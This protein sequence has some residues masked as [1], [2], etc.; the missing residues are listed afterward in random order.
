M[1]PSATGF[2]VVRRGYDQGQ[3]E[4][5]LRRLEAGFRLIATDRDAAVDQSAQLGRELDDARA[6][7]E[8]LRTQVRT[9]VSPPQSVQ[10]I[11]ERMRAM[12]RMA[13]DEVGEMLDNAKTTVDQRVREAEAQAARTVS[14]ARAEA[15]EVLVQA[16]TT[17]ERNTRGLVQERAELDT[18]RH[19]GAEALAE[20]R[21]TA[22]YSIAQQTA[23]AEQARA[24]AWAESEA[25]RA[26][27]EEDFTLAMDQRRRES[28]T[29][30]TAQRLDARRENEERRESSVTEARRTVADA[31]RQAQSIIG[32]ARRRVRELVALRARLVDQLGGARAVLDRSMAS[33]A[34]LPEELTTRPEQA[35][36]EQRKA[37]G[38]GAPLA[39]SA[40]SDL[41]A[42]DPSASVG[43]PA[44]ES[45]HNGHCD[46]ASI[47]GR[48]GTTG[49]AV[50]TDPGTPADPSAPSAD[51]TS[52]V[53]SGP[54]GSH[55]SSRS[56]PA[57]RTHSRSGT[58]SGR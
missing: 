14:D 44:A 52:A 30:L 10:G 40:E 41:G 35:V 27:I 28:L 53:A 49:R 37:R 50:R 32:E 42:P 11:S 55:P 5:H 20:Q 23:D 19:T 15:E 43:E 7:A 26:V 57:P 16:E 22:R 47:D 13:E 38:S 51:R 17:A 25:R 33:L 4:A 31:E 6:R 9:L 34:P 8:K 3:V 45:V 21:A 1:T 18:L 2:E 46:T 58:R 48:P 36:A 29:V 39:R 54:N 24:T 12:L 56:S